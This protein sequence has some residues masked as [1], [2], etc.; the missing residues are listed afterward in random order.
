MST[1]CYCSPFIMKKC[2]TLSLCQKFQLMFSDL[3]VFQ[4]CIQI[5]ELDFRALDL[6]ES[7]Y[8]TDEDEI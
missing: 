8:H 2:K 1:K 7:V 5:D 3:F 4:S 6:V